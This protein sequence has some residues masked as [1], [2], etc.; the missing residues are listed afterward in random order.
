M[1][2]KIDKL[3]FTEEDA[4]KYCENCEKKFDTEEQKCPICGANLI[5]EK[6]S[7]YDDTT[8]ETVATMTTLGIL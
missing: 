8:A 5:E 3:E 4:M 2:N 7:E 6:D 1:Y